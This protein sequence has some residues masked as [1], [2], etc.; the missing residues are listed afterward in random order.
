MRIAITATGADLD[1]SVEPR[2]G[3]CAYFVIVDPQTMVYESIENPNISVGGGAGIQ[4]AQLMAQ[5]GVYAVLTGNCGPN[6]FRVFEA[7]GIRVI[8]GVSGSVQKAV[9]QYNAGT[10]P[11]ADNPN[12]PSHFGM[13]GTMGYSPGSGGG[14]RAASFSYSAAGGGTGRGRGGGGRGMGCGGMGRGMGR[15]RGMRGG[16]QPGSFQIDTE[17]QQNGP[18]NI[19]ALKEQIRTIQ[20]RL[21]SLKEQIRDKEG[22]GK[23]SHLIARVK[24][25]KCTGC[26]ICQK[27]CPVGAI[28]FADSVAYIKA[29]ECTGC[30]RCAEACTQQA[31][32]LAAV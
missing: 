31:I 19:G 18:E 15:G 21:A 10:Q 16:M 25:E 26:R 7:A 8:T 20:E 32:V 17:E 29:D 28:S 23:E 11:N 24:P 13:G 14:S 2:F 22:R 27:V 3:R 4:S 9:S 12:V 5:K 1:S 30:G 6:A